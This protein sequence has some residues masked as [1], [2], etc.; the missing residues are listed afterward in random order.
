[1]PIKNNC[2]LCN[3]ILISSEEKSYGTHY[4]CPDERKDGPNYHIQEGEVSVSPF[5]VSFALILY[6][7][8]AI[9]L[10]MIIFLIQF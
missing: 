2:L 10:F 6:N 4:H 9:F 8:L 5:K 3:N 7:S 1:M